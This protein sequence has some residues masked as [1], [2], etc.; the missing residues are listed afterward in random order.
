MGADMLVYSL[1][2]REDTNPDWTR[3]EEAVKALS[4]GTNGDGLPKLAEEGIAFTQLEGE[5]PD[6]PEADKALRELVGDEL[7]VLKKAIDNYGTREG[8]REIARIGFDGWT[9][10][11]TG[12]LSWGDRPTELSQTFDLLEELEIT[13]AAGFFERGNAIEIQV[14]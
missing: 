6:G 5:H 13:D 14:A 3:A 10:Y 11:I 2:I 4:W 8:H 12:G 1:W 7:A 9:V